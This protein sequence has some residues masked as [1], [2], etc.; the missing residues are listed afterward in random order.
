VLSFHG[1]ADA[2]V[3]YGGGPINAG[4]SQ[5]LR[6]SAPPVED[7]VRQWA[8][9]NGC[10]LTPAEE[11]ASEHVRHIVYSGCEAGASVEFYA[12]DGGGH[13]WPGAAIDVPVLGPTAR[14][15]SATGLIWDFFAAHP[16]P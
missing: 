13:T 5:I 8:E 12:V 4:L 2:I 3:P 14:E 10:G 9:H 6:L 1:T 16:L 11:Q 7:A 15:I